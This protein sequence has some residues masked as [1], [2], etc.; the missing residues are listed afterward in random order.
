MGLREYKL[1]AFSEKNTNFLKP[2]QFNYN[3]M[4]LYLDY[5]YFVVGR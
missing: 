1:K 2:K 3:Q 5:G 4:S